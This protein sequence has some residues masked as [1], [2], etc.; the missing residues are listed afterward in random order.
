MPI[1]FNSPDARKQNKSDTPFPG[2]HQLV[3]EVIIL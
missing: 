2:F 3:Y 1:V